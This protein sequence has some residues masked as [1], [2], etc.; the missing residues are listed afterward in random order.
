MTATANGTHRLSESE[1]AT[2]AEGIVAERM[3][4][5]GG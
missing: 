1:T 4:N 3:T 2:I 5:P